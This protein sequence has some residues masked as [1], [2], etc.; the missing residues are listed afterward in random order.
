MNKAVIFDWGGVF[1][2]TTDYT[3]RH[4]WDQKLD[5]PIGSVEST[6]H[7]SEIWRAAQRGEISLDDYWQQTGLDL[8]LTPEQTHQ[9][10]HD[11]YSGDTIDTELVT[12]LNNLHEASIPCGLMSNNSLD[13][14]DTLKIHGLFNLF[15]ACIIS[16]QIGVMKPSPEAYHAILD[17]MTVS[18]QNAL[19][20]DDFIENVEGARKVGMSA[21]HYTPNLDLKTLIF[22]WVES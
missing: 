13:L 8:S 1:M 7:G 20:I 16:A 15:T 2:R 14:I 6:V 11:F 4:A 10:R 3:P 5:L 9:L 12:L 21:I 22:E 17:K 18:P 19:F